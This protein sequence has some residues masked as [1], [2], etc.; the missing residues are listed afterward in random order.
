MNTPTYTEHEESTYALLMRSQEEERSLPETAVYLL[1]ILTMAFSVWQTA[2]QRFQLPSI[3]LL[4]GA[5]I[6]Q[7]AEPNNSSA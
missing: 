4:Q 7:A 5:S 6:V 3:G 1:L 2:Q